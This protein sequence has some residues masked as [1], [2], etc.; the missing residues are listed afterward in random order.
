M[1]YYLALSWTLKNI[2]HH[3]SPTQILWN[4]TLL[5]ERTSLPV[6]WSTSAYSSSWSGPAHMSLPQFTRTSRLLL[7]SDFSLYCC[8][9]YSIL[10]K[11]LPQNPSA[12]SLN[13]HSGLI[14][15]YLSLLPW[16]CL[17]GHILACLL[18]LLLFHK[19][20]D[21]CRQNH[22]FYHII[23][24]YILSSFAVG[25]L[26]GVIFSKNYMFK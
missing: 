25:G 14:N 2:C 5:G 10:G 21:M 7:W 19:W 17:F 8:G 13:R 11:V 18:N 4:C 1:T 9:G 22:A 3:S 6:L 15:L 24:T 12:S 23:I 20:Y 26:T 16:S